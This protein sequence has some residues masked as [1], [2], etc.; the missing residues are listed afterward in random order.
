[1]GYLRRDRDAQKA[2]YTAR[3]LAASNTISDLQKVCSINIVR[4]STLSEVCSH[5]VVMSRQGSTNLAAIS[6]YFN[7]F[8]QPQTPTTLKVSAAIYLFR[9]GIIEVSGHDFHTYLSPFLRRLRQLQQDPELSFIGPLSFLGRYRS[10]I[11]EAHVGMINGH[12]LRQSGDLGH[13]FRQ[14][15]RHLISRHSKTRMIVSTDS[16]ARCRFSAV[17]FARSLSGRCQSSRDSVANPLTP[18]SC[19]SCFVDSSGTR[20]VR[21]QHRS[22]G[23]PRPTHQSELAH[24]LSGCGSNCRTRVDG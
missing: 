16:A 8:R 19:Y 21:S 6:P 5:A 14:R 7:V 10:W 12:G 2:E 17:E 9:H 22:R 18:H 15:Y 24:D 1:M 20:Y 13:A 11:T 23:T 3:V 4:V